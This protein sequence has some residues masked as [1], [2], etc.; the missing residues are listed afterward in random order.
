MLKGI[1][2]Y[3]NLRTPFKKLFIYLYVNFFFNNPFCSFVLVGKKQPISIEL[4]E[5]QAEAAGDYDPYKHRKV[6][7]PTT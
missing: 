7:H 4:T 5:K 3:F 2:V 6:E 1:S